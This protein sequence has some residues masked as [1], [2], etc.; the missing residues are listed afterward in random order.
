MKTEILYRTDMKDMSM[1]TDMSTATD[2]KTA[3]AMSTNTV[4]RAA[5]APVR[6][7]VIIMTME[8]TARP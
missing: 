6:G 1:A 5:A 4:M 8:M 7:T 3:T 2:M